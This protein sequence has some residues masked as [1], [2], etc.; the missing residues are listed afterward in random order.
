MEEKFGDFIKRLRI[1]KGISINCL[2]ERSGF[3]QMEIRNIENNKTKPRVY[4]LNKLADALGCT[5]ECLFNKM[6]K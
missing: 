2:S 6:D 4:N 3:T 1:E 5:F